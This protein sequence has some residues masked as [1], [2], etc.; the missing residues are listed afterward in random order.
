MRQHNQQGDVQFVNTF[1]GGEICFE[2]GKIAMSGGLET[3]VFLSLFGGNISTGFFNRTTYWGDV[4]ETD[5][6]FFA[7]GETER[8][9]LDNV[10]SRNSLLLLK[11]AIT[12][13][14]SWILEKNVAT[15]IVIDV[16]VLTPNVVRV[17]LEI[18]ADGVQ[19]DITFNLN[20]LAQ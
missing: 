10:L 9:V 16:Q 6:A 8:V 5:G 3:A 15:D 14:L 1:D 11:D 17:F 7:K 18:S 13:D 20:W 2:N 19:N 4:W 12:R